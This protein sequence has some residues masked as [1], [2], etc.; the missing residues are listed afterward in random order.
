MD[1]LD[2][3]AREVRESIV[4]IRR[5]ETELQ[6]L[7]LGWRPPDGGWSIAQVFEHLIIAE[8]SYFA[9]L[10]RILEKG[11]KGSDEYSA[12]LIGGFIIRAL[13]PTSTRKVSAPG[14]YKPAPEPRAHVVA[15]Y[16]KVR[17][18]LL[19]YIERAKG[20][21]LRRNRLSSPVAK[22]IRVNLGD[23]FEMAVVHTKR[24]LQQIERLRARPE[25][26]ARTASAV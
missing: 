7:Q 8:S 13:Q 16:I 11:R 24:H 17:A 23:V 1:W 4:A 25:F 3:R 15:E 19:G 12:S 22:I 18:E 20:L 2:E 10:R 21:D 6:Y 26:P 5:I 14:I 9:D